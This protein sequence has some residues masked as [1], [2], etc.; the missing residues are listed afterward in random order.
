MEERKVTSGECSAILAAISEIRETNQQSHDDLREMI[1]EAIR[2]VHLDIDANAK[3]TNSHLGNID[4]KF[5]VLNGSVARLKE[6]VEKGRA[7]AADFRK[8]ERELGVIRRKW[9]YSIAGLTGLILTVLVIYDVIG[10]RGIIELL[11]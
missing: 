1:H 7:V 10:L 5:A 2:G 3:V 6:D 8:L 4:N 11:K 9:L